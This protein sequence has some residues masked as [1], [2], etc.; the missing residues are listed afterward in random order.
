MLEGDT[1]MEDALEVA[2]A[3][4]LR[5]TVEAPVELAPDPAPAFLSKDFDDAPESAD[6]QAVSK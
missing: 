5:L 3:D 6:F 4:H 1:P 2:I